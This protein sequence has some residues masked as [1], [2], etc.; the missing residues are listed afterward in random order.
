[1]SMSIAK[2]SFQKIVLAFFVVMA[3]GLT[4]PHADDDCGKPVRL[5]DAGGSMD[6]VPVLD[7][8]ALPICYA[9]SAATLLQTWRCS[10]GATDCGQASVSPVS[11]SVNAELWEVN[12]HIIDQDSKVSAFWGYKSNEVQTA[13]LF[14]GPY[15]D[16]AA[17]QQVSDTVTTES[18]I[19]NLFTQYKKNCVRS[20]GL[21][22]DPSNTAN[23]ASCRSMGGSS[24]D[25]PSFELFA[26]TAEAC[27]FPRGGSPVDVKTIETALVESN[28]LL[29]IQGIIAEQCSKNPVTIPTMPRLDFYRIAPLHKSDGPDSIKIAAAKKAIDGEFDRLDHKGQPIFT[30]YC[31]DVLGAGRK[32]KFNYG[33]DCSTEHASLII[34]RRK[35]P[36][37]PHS[38]QYLVRN[39][40][41]KNC[42]RDVKRKYHYS[43]DWDC[44]ASKGDYWID[45]EMM[46]KSA[47]EIGGVENEGI[48]GLLSKEYESS[49]TP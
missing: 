4:H 43:E 1:M 25:H 14:R 11:I 45:Q 19:E 36:K 41:G 32:S 9:F 20:A 13:A 48:G 35:N 21:G 16:Q 30:T 22:L 40:W 24:F 17:I 3:A 38:C 37:E 47:F 42:D 23:L 7:Q 44:D 33:A 18:A 6:N 10:H 27:L 49:H 28:P 34:G 46:L 12:H 5:D 15:C 29:I 39:S 31:A 2:I 8:Q 26:Q